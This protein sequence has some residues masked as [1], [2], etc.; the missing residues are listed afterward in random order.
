MNRCTGQ[1]IYFSLKKKMKRGLL[2]DS[3]TTWQ[4]NNS[5][6]TEIDYLF[7]CFVA[8][9]PKSTAMVMAG[10]SVHLLVTDNDSAEGRRMT[11]KV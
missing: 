4:L 10:R 1:L 11:I 5:C 9:R 3:K 8:L 6:K 2:S 7:V